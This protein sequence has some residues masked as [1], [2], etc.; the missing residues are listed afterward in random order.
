M[1]SIPP[2]TEPVSAAPA[3]GALRAPAETAPSATKFEGP[4]F[5]RF[6][7]FV[8]LFLLVLGAVVVVATRATGQARIVPEG[9][10]FLFAGLG[11]ALMLYH[12]VT[13]GE[14]E[15]RRMYG[16]LAATFLVLALAAAVLPGPFKGT[17]EKVNGYYFLPWGLGAG[18]L[19]LLFAVPFVRHETDELLNRI[20]GYTL[21]GVGSLLCLGVLVKG[22]WEP[23]WLAGP[24]L[25]LAVLG[26]GFLC[27]YLGQADTDDGIGYTVAFTLGAVGGAAILYAFARTVFPTVLYDGPSVLR[28]ASQ[29]LDYWKAAGRALVILLFLGL[30]A[31][32]VLGKY[33]IWLRATVGG[34]GV[35]CAGVF[36]L[37]G[38]KAMVTTPPQAFMVPGGLIIGGLGLVYLAVS[39]GACSDS[40]FVTL[41]RRE[42]S[43]YFLS[44]V[45][46]LVLGGMAVAQWIGYVQFVSRIDQMSAG[47]RGIVPEPIVRFYIV[48]LFPIIALKLQVAALTMRLFAEEKKNG[49]LEVLFT[50]PVSEWV[51]VL[52]KF[53]ATWVFFMIC[54]LPAGLFLIVLRME[55]GA[56]FDYRPL[57]GFYVALGA[58]GAAFVAMGMFLS[59]LTNNQI[60][61]A[62]LTFLGMLVFLATYVIAAFNIGL[63]P[64]FQVFLNKLSYIELW[65]MSLSGQLPVRDVL[66]WLSLAVFFVFLTIKV[67]ET[68][69]WS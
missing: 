47:G 51:S 55:G 68:R 21:L 16:M 57:L 43:S 6:V 36:L 63:G 33:P 54:W 38:T 7:G 49:T 22:V 34:V 40:Q 8:G 14:Q 35:V 13:D 30:V 69:R 28:N 27:A 11:I 45:G 48:A 62:V 4:T 44:N 61:A 50:A 32:G 26:L 59:S 9:W 41:V 24:G 25:A 20:G 65:S 19:A 5:A 56:T 37:A 29:A 60:V 10:G 1:S 31:L 42:L 3:V 52:S 39:L 58:T 17:I 46:Y 15:V 67:L 2:A 12:A 66:L 64:T 23:V 53:L 18:F